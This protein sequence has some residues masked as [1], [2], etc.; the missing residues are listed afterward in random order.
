M[1]TIKHLFSGL[2]LSLLLIVG[3]AYASSED[4]T[5]VDPIDSGDYDE[6]TDSTCDGDTHEHIHYN[7]STD[8]S[9]RM[10]IGVVHEFAI[11][12]DDDF[13]DSVD[14]STMTCT[15]GDDTYRDCGFNKDTDLGDVVYSTSNGHWNGVTVTYQTLNWI[16][17]DPVGL[18]WEYATDSD[19]DDYDDNPWIGSGGQKV[20]GISFEADD[21]TIESSATTTSWTKMEYFY[22]DP[23][24]DYMD[25]G[26]W[27]H[28]YTSQVSSHSSAVDPDSDYIYWYGI[29]GTVVSNFPACEEAVTCESLSITPETGDLDMSDVLSD[30]NFT[31]TATGSDGSNITGDS[32]FTY[33]LNKYGSS[34]TAGD[35]DGG[36]KYGYSYVGRSTPATTSDST[37]TFKNTEP[38][39]S[40]YVYVSDYEGDSYRSTCYA[41][42]QLPYCTDL[43]ITDP[44]GSFGSAYVGSTSG[45]EYETNITIDTD[46]SSGTESWPFDVTY[47]STDSTATF[48]G[49]STPYTTTDNTIASYLSTDS[50]TVD[51][52]IDP[53]YDVAGTCNDSFYYTLIPTVTI[54][55][56]G[57]L[58]ITT[59]TAPITEAAMEAGDVQISWTSTLTD[60]TT[61]PSTFMCT[62]SNPTGSF[63]DVTGMTSTATITTPMTT[64]YY[65]GEPGDTI[66]C[67]SVT[68]YSGGAC[69]D[70]ITS[71]EDTTAPVCEDLSLGTP[72]ITNETTGRSDTIDLSDQDDL[73]LMYRD[74]TVCFPFEVNVESGF[75]GTLQASGYTDSTE[76]TLSSGLLSLTVDSVGSYVGNPATVGITGATTYTGTVCWENFDENYVLNLEVVGSESVCS[77]TVTL[78]PLEETPPPE[79][80]DDDDSHGGGG[81]SSGDDDDDLTCDEVVDVNDNDESA[82]CEEYSMEVCVEDDDIEVVSDG[83]QI[84]Y[85]DQSDTDHSDPLDCSDD[86]LTIPGESSRSCYDVII[87]EGNVCESD[88]TVEYNGDICETFSPEQAEVGVLNKFIY[89]FNFISNQVF[90]SDK[91]VFFSHDEDRAFYTLEYEPSGAESTLVFTDDMWDSDGVEGVF[92]DGDNGLT[93]GHV[94]L[95]ESFGD[96]TEY[97]YED[98]KRFGFGDEYEEG[99]GDLADIVDGYTDS[100]SSYQTF[101]PYLKYP[102]DGNNDT[103]PSDV[104]YAC[105]PSENEEGETVYGE[106]GILCYNPEYTP[107]EDGRIVIL[108]AD[109]IPSD[110][111]LRI[112]YIGIVNSGIIDNCDNESDECLT[113]IFENSAKVF[114]DPADV[115]DP[116]N[117][118]TCDEDSA[119]S[120]DSAKLVV[121]CSYLQTQNGGDIYLEGDLNS[122]ADIS[123][124]Y[125]D[126]EQNYSSYSNTDG[127]VIREAEDSDD[128]DDSTSSSTESTGSATYYDATY[129]L[130]NVSLCDDASDDNFIGNISSYVCEIVSAVSDLWKGSTVSSTTDSNVEQSIR[131]ADTAQASDKERYSSFAAMRTALENANNEDSGILYFQGEEG[132]SSTITL[133][134][135]SGYFD[136]PCGAWTLIVK[137]ADL[138]IS[139]DTLRYDTSCTA[140]SGMNYTTDLPSIAFVVEDGDIYIE[141]SAYNLVGVY[142]TNQ[143]ITGDTRSAVDGSLEIDGSIYGNIN[144]LLDAANYVG[145]PD[146]N[147][148]SVVVRYDSR[149]LLN[150]PPGLSEYVDVDTQKGVN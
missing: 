141:D 91:D 47:E 24:G 98:I 139:A 83:D 38:G 110:A 115:E 125:I 124:A 95:A 66:T 86:S 61:N 16:D 127:L 113:E 64:V 50:A 78:P 75:S 76:S 55:S 85:Y 92:G 22:T 33:Y 5:E 72:T 51:V 116:E 120:E 103:D 149:I 105:G 119:C 118:D 31:V 67:M 89:T 49:N 53:E 6:G 107:E 147:G 68:P 81:H 59:P 140:D 57:T 87:D 29:N 138:H 20:E 126:D 62:S 80:D 134:G 114:A 121:L 94:N 142:Y 18:L 30:V 11:V 100:E 12:F 88:I 28:V 143:D 17:G 52:Y 26:N 69:I 129:S 43:D 56:C 74:D 145:P 96:L 71:E 35:A 108:N 8:T 79:G 46:T 34:D 106:D 130:D 4:S 150:T 101:V 146:L 37:V 109:G 77:D 111:T 137:D 73:E 1:K 117:T 14:T 97:K 133:T 135:T 104:I 54:P 65:T 112:R 60:G 63:R 84:C 36:L 25:T 32:E 123:C 102:S 45:D 2:S 148:G 13:L 21:Y 42:V 3:V 19:A 90:D 48:D 136:I 27:H 15:N 132:G 144:P 7:D 41:E 23:D 40:L 99:S 82:I 122:G 39:D 10:Y 9:S 70:T 128:D 44:T 58:E 93:Q 131:N